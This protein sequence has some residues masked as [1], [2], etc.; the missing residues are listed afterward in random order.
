[1]MLN[2]T[3][4]VITTVTMRLCKGVREGF[5][6]SYLVRYTS[7]SQDKNGIVFLT[8][9]SSVCDLITRQ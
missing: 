4:T 3:I 7:S 8:V 6:F 1:M 5:S 9:L 2:T